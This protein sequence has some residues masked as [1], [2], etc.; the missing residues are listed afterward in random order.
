MAIVGFV[1]H[2][3]TCLSMAELEAYYTFCIS[4]TFTSVDNK[5]SAS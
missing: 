3:C 2:T 1:P 5:A 4:C